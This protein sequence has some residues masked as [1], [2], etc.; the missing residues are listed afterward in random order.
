MEKYLEAGMIVNTHGVRGDIKA[1]S[2]CDS[3]AVLAGLPTIYLKKSDGSLLPLKVTKG[4]V[5]KGMAL[6]KLE[7]IDDINDAVRFKNMVIWADR[8]DIPAREGSYFI[9]DLIGLPVIDADNDEIVYGKVK[10][11][12]EI[13]G[14]QLY[15][16]ETEGGIKLIPAVKEFIIRIDPE[17]GVYLRPIEGLLE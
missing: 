3:P 6:L 13:G 8:E 1:E 15:E 10:N 9:A 7:G 14:R 17:K 16:V 2:W 4:S 11:V 12:T 5:H